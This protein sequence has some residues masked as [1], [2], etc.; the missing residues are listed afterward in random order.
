VKA[1]E[2][3][4]YGEVIYAVD[5]AKQSNIEVVGLVPR[6]DAVVVPGM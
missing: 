1:D 6:K 3:V 2:D 5:T 4:K